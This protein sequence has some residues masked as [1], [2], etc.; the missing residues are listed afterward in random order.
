MGTDKKIIVVVVAVILAI[1]ITVGTLVFYKRPAKINDVSYEVQEAG[2]YSY[3]DLTVETEGGSLLGS[4]TPRYQFT[5]YFEGGGSGG[6]NM[7]DGHSEGAYSQELGP[8]S[9][10]TEVWIVTS[11]DTGTGIEWEQL[12]VRIGGEPAA[13]GD[14]SLAIGD[15]SDIPDSMEL[16]KGKEI[17]VDI[18]GERE[19]TQVGLHQAYHYRYGDI[20]TGSGSGGGGGLVVKE[21]DVYKGTVGTEHLHDAPSSYS[22]VLLFRISA[23]DENRSAVSQTYEVPL[24]S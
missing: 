1:G 11:L 12:T 4:P 24:E 14:G 9:N 15:I 8:F 18:E 23:Y 10:G 22:G 21:G 19:N 7:W 6:G 17:T 16:K 13:N 20:F 5:S 3:I 2:R